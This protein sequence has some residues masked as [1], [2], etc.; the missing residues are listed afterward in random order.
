MKTWREVIE[1]MEVEVLEFEDT[2]ESVDKASKLAGYP[3]NLIVKTI[4]LRA[5]REYIVALVRGDRRVDLER[6]NRLLGVRVELAKPREVRTVLGV[7]PG[8]VTPLSPNVKRLR[9]VADPSIAGLD[10]VLCGGGSLNRLYKV[11]TSDLFK[12]L[13]PEFLDVFV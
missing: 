6:V 7:E 9:V 8:A 2:V 1:G 4:L 3:R 11:K 12:Y 13:N 10:Y 5:P